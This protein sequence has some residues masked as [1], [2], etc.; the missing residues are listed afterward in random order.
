MDEMTEKEDTGILKEDTGLLS[1]F[2]EDFSLLIECGFIASK[3]MDEINSNRIFNA[4]RAIN[5]TSSAPLVGLGHISLLKMDIKT[6]T[7]FFEEAIAIEEDNYLAFCF[8]GIC[9]LLTKDKGKKGEKII[10]EAIE[11]TDDETVRKLGTTTLEWAA[12]ELPGKRPKAP[13]EM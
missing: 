6:A 4:A 2:K 5:P 1:E 7:K 13:F 8:L 10:K 9:L 12:T 3:Q 11:K